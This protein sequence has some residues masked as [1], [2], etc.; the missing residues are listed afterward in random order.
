[1][2][3]QRWQ[4]LGRHVVA[5]AADGC[6]SAQSGAAV[7]QGRGPRHLFEQARRGLAHHRRSRHRRAGSPR[8]QRRA[9]HRRQPDDQCGHHPTGPAAFS[10]AVH[11]KDGF[12]LLAPGCVDDLGRPE[13]PV[14]Q[15]L[16]RSSR[17]AALKP[18]SPYTDIF[19]L[20][21]PWPGDTVRLGF[22]RGVRT[23]EKADEYEHG[24]VSLQECVIPALVSHRSPVAASLGVLSVLVAS[25]TLLP[26]MLSFTGA[27]VGATRARGRRRGG[28]R[29]PEQSPFWA[30]WVG[31][32][33]R[34]P[35]VAAA[36]VSLL[37]GGRPNQMATA[38]AAGAAAGGASETMLT[39]FCAGQ[40]AL[41]GMLTPYHSGGCGRCTGLSTIGT[42]S[43][44]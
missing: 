16:T 42:L 4:A 5:R 30:R 26:A 2:T 24:G 8:P 15:A 21:S 6:D 37:T 41:S 39:S 38:I 35:A 7:A 25:L 33:Q 31:A 22:P 9:A 23:L 44:R 40:S 12:L 13:V 32:I 28:S 19:T 43:K 17:Y 34:R 10:A 3:A 36:I 29:S 20:P 27:R 18:D 11:P 1:V 14:A